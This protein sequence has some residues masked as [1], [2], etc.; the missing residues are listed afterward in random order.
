MK[1]ILI[2]SFLLFGVFLHAQEEFSNHISKKEIQF[3][4]NYFE[5][6]KYKVLEEYEKSLVLYEKC[7][8][9]YPEESSPYNEIAK[10]YFYLQD[11]SNAEYY[12]NEAI[13]LDSNN[14]WYYYLLLDIYFV[15]GNL[16]SQ[17]I[18]YTQLINLDKNQ[19]TYYIQ[20]LD[21]LRQLKQYKQAIKFIKESTKIFG[22]SIVLIESEIDIHLAQSNFKLAE[23]TAQKLVEFFPKS[24]SS[25]S[26]LA[27]VYLHF[28]EYEKAI[29]IYKQLLSNDSDNAE[30]LIA[31]YQIY[32][33]KNDLSEQQN[34]LAKIASNKEIDLDTKKDIFYKLLLENDFT[35]FTSFQ[36]IVESAL[37]LA[38]E[39]PLLNLI[40]G[41]I[42]TKQQSL[43]KAIIHY[44]YALNSTLVKA[45]YVYN[46]LLEI[47][48]KQSDYASVIS[49]ASEAI[50]KHPFNPRLFYLKALAYINTNQHPMAL[51]TLLK[52]VDIVI[53][54]PILKSEFYSLL[55]DVYHTLDNH[56]MSDESYSL[57]LEYNSNNTFVLNNYSYYLAL[58]EE[59]LNLALEMARH[60]NALT[61]DQPNSSFLDTYAW[62]LY[63]LKKYKLAKDQILKALEINTNSGTLYDHYGDIL[64]ELGDVASA[65]IQWKRA[66]ALDIN[67]KD[68]KNKI[69]TNE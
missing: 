46:K 65:I 31:L 4:N 48:F 20:K 33:N 19:F 54:D 55:G 58:R 40:L 44:K 62:V 11:W 27:R 53:D 3:L 24:S 17:V 12:I 61:V 13:L 7:I 21:L 10:I 35:K 52:G 2:Y 41:D 1:K 23:K 18:V 56:L 30:A 15:Q 29:S 63:K 68:L 14:K 69:Y 42:S 39:D 64:Y 50:E 37:K 25:Y 16:Q 26:A 38:P 5:A 6:E 51:E 57:S 66:L 45:E 60:C 43:D 9:I 8:S 67:N 49:T 59:N 34:Y 28:S 32:S 36:M 47:F 22:K